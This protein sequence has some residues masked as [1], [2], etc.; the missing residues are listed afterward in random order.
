MNTIQILNKP[1]NLNQYK[2][3]NAHVPQPSEHD[4]EMP[5]CEG[6]MREL[7]EINKVESCESKEQ[8]EQRRKVEILKRWEIRIQPLDRGCVVHVGCKSIAFVSIE[9][10]HKEIGRYIGNP[11]LVATQHGFGDHF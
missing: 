6:P 7:T 10:A 2:M 8:R 1:N 9:S 5:V 4:E 3:I 11:Q